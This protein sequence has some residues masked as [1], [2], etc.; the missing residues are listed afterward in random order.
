[1]ET[2]ETLEWK[3]LQAIAIVQR[4]DSVLLDEGG[5][6]SSM[7]AKKWLYSGQVDLLMY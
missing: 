2:L 7:G 1:M 3:Q 5:S 4:R 6:S